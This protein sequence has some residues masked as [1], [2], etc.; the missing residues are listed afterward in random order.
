M[1]VS[2]LFNNDSFENNGHTLDDVYDRI[3]DLDLLTNKI[4]TINKRKK[5][6]GLEKD[7]YFTDLDIYEKNIYKDLTICD[8]INNYTEVTRDYK[9][10]LGSIINKSGTLNGEEID[11]EIGLFKNGNSLIFDI[12]DLTNF[13][14]QFFQTLT[15]S[16]IF[17]NGIK[18]HF[19]NITLSINVSDTL[20][21]IEQDLQN[22]AEKFVKTLIYLN[23]RIQDVFNE[24]KDVRATLVRLTEE[25]S[26]HASVQGKSKDKLNFEFQDSKSK[27][28]LKFICDPHVKY[29]SGEEAKVEKEYYRLYFHMGDPK[30]DNGNILI[31]HI[32]KHIE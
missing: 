16:E 6:L 19:Q 3:D 15:D 30:I 7:Q 17:Y 22:F 11:Q 27:E 29:K 8:F 4:E 31:G 12:D 2:F 18:I 13:Y 9:V 1:T 10:L 24:T 28:K 23:D 21:E 5:K 32:G 20:N 26:F 25:I 14:Y